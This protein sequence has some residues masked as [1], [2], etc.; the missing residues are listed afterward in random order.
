MSVHDALE[1]D[2]VWLSWMLRAAEHRRLSHAIAWGPHR[3]RN[4]EEHRRHCAREE[5][6]A[7]LRSIADRLVA[8]TAEREQLRAAL[9]PFARMA[10]KLEG[11]PGD[12]LISNPRVHTPLYVNDFRIAARVFEETA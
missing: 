12:S 5:N 4:V 8:L 3:I 10:P 9:A 11:A 6:V 2:I 7:R 1:A